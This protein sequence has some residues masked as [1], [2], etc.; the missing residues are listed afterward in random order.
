MFDASN[1]R[2]PVYLRYVNDRDLS[3]HPV[4]VGAD[5]GDLGPEGLLVGNKISGTTAIYE[6]EVT[7][8]Q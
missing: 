2:A 5:A 3:L 7:L 4:A 8:L 6:I 1:P